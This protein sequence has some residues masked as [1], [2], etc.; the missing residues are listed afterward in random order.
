MHRVG[1]LLRGH[2]GVWGSARSVREFRGVL[3]EGAPGQF[4]DGHQHIKK[5]NSCINIMKT[6]DFHQHLKKTNISASAY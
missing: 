4:G 5:T 1:R 6:S 2:W 3:G